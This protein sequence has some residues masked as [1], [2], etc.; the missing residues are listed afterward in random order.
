MVDLCSKIGGDPIEA[1]KK[2]GPHPEKPLDAS[3]KVRADR[4]TMDMVEFCM[5]KLQISRSEVLRRGVHCLYEQLNG[6]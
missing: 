6:K 4:K 5:E 1:R 2:P 3:M